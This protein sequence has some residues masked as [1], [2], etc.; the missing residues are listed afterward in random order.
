VARRHRAERTVRRAPGAS[1]TVRVEITPS[2]A[3]GSVVTGHLY[4]DTANLVT[5]AGDE[6]ISLPYKY[7]VR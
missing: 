5:V 6:L 2:G 4:I 7:T 3:A 1:G